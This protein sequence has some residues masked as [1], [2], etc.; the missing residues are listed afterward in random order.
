MCVYVCVFVSSCAV[1]FFL[2]ACFA[3]PGPVHFRFCVLAGHTQTTPTGDRITHRYHP[4]RAS[5][6]GASRLPIVASSCCLLAR[7]RLRLLSGRST[8]G[9]SKRFDGAA[10]TTTTT[11]N[12][13]DNDN[14][15]PRQNSFF[16]ISYKCFICTTSS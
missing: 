9:D 4:H 3:F 8:A 2:S 14:N 5:T 6:S 15:K 1:Y 11:T 12:D 13:N 16:F 7:L 10:T